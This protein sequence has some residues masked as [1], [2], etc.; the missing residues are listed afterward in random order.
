MKQ[1]KYLAIIPARKGS[2]G[3][4][5]KNIRSLQGKPLLSYPLIAARNSRYVDDVIISTDSIEYARIAQDYGATFKGLR[6]KNIAD[7]YFG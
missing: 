7:E 2:K 4:P 1:K 3:L 6:P 5:G